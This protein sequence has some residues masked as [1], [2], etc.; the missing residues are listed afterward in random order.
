MTIIRRGTVYSPAVKQPYSEA[1]INN[2]NHAPNLVSLGDGKCLAAWFSGPWEGHP[3]QRILMSRFDGEKWSEAKVLQN[4]EGVSDFD[5]AFIRSGSRICLFYS[6][7][8]WFI[9]QLHG[10]QRGALGTYYRWSDDEGGSWSEPHLLSEKNLCKSN[11]CCL[12]NGYLLLPVYNKSVNR[13]GVFKSTDEGKNWELHESDP[14]D[15]GIAEPS[16]VELTEGHILIIARTKTG[17][18]WKSNQWM[19]ERTGHHQNL[20]I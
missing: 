7:A 18:L 10:E 16:V 3:F 15:P 4:T 20:Q 19:P 5:P 8:R 17:T 11:G 1:Y 9:P 6:N 2:F 12:E 13:V 14:I